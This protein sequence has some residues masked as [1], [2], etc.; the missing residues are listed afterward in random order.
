MLLLGSAFSFLIHSPT[1]QLMNQQAGSSPTGAEGKGSAVFC[2][3]H[4][5]PGFALPL[6]WSRQGPALFSHAG[7]T[8]MLAVRGA[9]GSRV[10]SGSHLAVLGSC[11]HKAPSSAAMVRNSKPHSTQFPT[12]R[13]NG[14]VREEDAC[15]L[16]ELS[17]VLTYPSV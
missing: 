3:R 1:E 6:R 11:L 9:S 15:L 4:P 13:A 8:M 17:L 7:C 10:C 2:L 12:V 14:A 5:H 16:E